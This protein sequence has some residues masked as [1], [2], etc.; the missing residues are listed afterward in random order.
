MIE[1]EQALPG[2]I[3]EGVRRSGPGLAAVKPTLAQS[4]SCFLEG[5]VAPAQVARGREDLTLAFTE[6]QFRNMKME[7]AVVSVKPLPESMR[8]Q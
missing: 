8:Y 6:Q 3:F 1:T 5:A 7:P 4:D 2:G